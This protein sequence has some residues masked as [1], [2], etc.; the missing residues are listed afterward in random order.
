MLVLGEEYGKK[1]RSTSETDSKELLSHEQELASL[2]ESLLMIVIIGITILFPMVLLYS[3]GSDLITDLAALYC[4]RVSSNAT[5]ALPSASCKGL[6]TVVELINSQFSMPLWHFRFVCVLISFCIHLLLELSSVNGCLWDKSPLDS[7]V[8]RGSLKQTIFLDCI[9]EISLTSL[10]GTRGAGTL[11]RL[12]AIFSASIKSVWISLRVLE[13]FS[14]SRIS[15]EPTSS[16]PEDSG[17]FITILPSA[18]EF[19]GIL[20]EIT[21]VWEESKLSVSLWTWCETGLCFSLCK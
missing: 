16:K 14:V 3:S 6:L 11:Y 10:K 7:S 20:F 5:L 19:K 12:S 8:V 13:L 2:L 4:L 9:N 17:L 1:F 18:W 21:L 15:S